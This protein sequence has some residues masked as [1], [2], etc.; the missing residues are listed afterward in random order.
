MDEQQQR[1]V[2]EAAEQFTS[3]LVDSF[4]AVSGRGERA[5]E[6]SAQLTQDFF[7]R[8][9]ENLRTQAEDT[10]QMTH[11]LAD[12]HQRATEAGRTLGQESVGA[13]MDFVNSMFSFWSGS[14]EAFQGGTEEAQRTAT[15]TPAERQAGVEQLPIENYDTLTVQQVSERLDDLSAE[16]IR[17]LRAY[18]AE[19]KSR[20]TLL[21]RLDER[22]EAGS[23]S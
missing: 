18:E 11:Q 5:Q 14:T 1:R 17:Q 23:P 19:N 3:A 8:V 22:I 13:Y 10:Q 9:V 4:R 20:S 16:E 6:Q 2:N 12:Q 21:R 7:N 15:E